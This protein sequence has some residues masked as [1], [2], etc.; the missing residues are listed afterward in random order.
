MKLDASFC[1]LSRFLK[2]SLV[3][4]S[5]GILP[6]CHQQQVKP[7]Q[8]SQAVS[9]E[10]VKIS[11][12]NTTAD[13]VAS[14]AKSLT[15]VAAQARLPLETDLN[16]PTVPDDAKKFIGRYHTEIECDGRFAP[17][18][19]GTA[20]FILTLLPDGT[21][22]RSILQYGKVFIDN[23]KNTSANNIT[24]RKERWFINP[25]RTEVVVNRREG[26]SF[27]YTIKDAN[28]LVMNLEKI[29]SEK[30]RVNRE[31]FDRG[32]PAPSKAYELVKDTSFHIKQ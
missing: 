19:E 10:G 2:C 31:L 28:H 26:A 17:C 5:M 8:E 3:L 25:E 27:Y 13:V 32:Y 12:A 30:E 22:H 1:T 6:A 18:S 16:P 21:V 7:E 15:Q 4:G 29:Y 20:K 24:Y 14:S 23:T 9:E 11:A